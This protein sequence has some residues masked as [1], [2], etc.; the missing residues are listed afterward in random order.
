MEKQRLE[1]ERFVGSQLLAMGP[2]FGSLFQRFAFPN[3]NDNSE[4][5][6]NCRKRQNS[7]DIDMLKDNKILK[8][9]L[10]EGI[11]K[12]MMGEDSEND[13]SGIQNDENSNSSK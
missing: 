10:S 5:E 7:C 3:D 2:F 12:Y 9:L 11:K 13:D 4:S 6:K 8:T 1:F